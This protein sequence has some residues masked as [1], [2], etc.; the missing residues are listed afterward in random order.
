MFVNINQFQM[1]LFHPLQN[2]QVS[3]IN[4]CQNFVGSLETVQRKFFSIMI[5]VMK[6]FFC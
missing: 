4:D 1:V 3:A 6:L 5:N 2:N